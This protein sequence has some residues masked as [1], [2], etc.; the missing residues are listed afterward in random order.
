MIDW[1]DTERSVAATEQMLT[2]AARTSVTGR[3]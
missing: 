1:G 3:L 2:A